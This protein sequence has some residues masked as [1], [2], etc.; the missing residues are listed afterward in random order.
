MKIKFQPM[1][2]LTFVVLICLG[3]L[4]TLG[5]WQYKRLIWKTGVLAEI[6]EAAQSTPILSLA[7]IN[8][9][10]QSGKPIEFLRVSLDV[11]FDVAVNNRH[12]PFHL[13]RSNGKSFSWRHYQA[14]S[15]VDRANLEHHVL[16]YMAT[17]EFTEA[18]KQTPPSPMQAQQKIFGYVRKVQA[19]NRFIPK[20]DPETNRWFAFNAQPDILDWGDNGRIQTAYYIDVQEQ[21]TRVEDLAVRIPEIPNNHLDYMLTWYSFAFILLVIYF[22]LHKRAGR[23]RIERV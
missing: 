2:W 17:R 7:D 15:D 1:P 10:L 11:N 22:L 14:A 8:A 23:F 18:Q 16:A 20:S 19:A 3:I 21:V 9:R 12:E 5:T 6:E 4:L 13:M